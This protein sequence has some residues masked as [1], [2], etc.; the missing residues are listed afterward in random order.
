MIK[1]LARPDDKE[2]RE[3]FSLLRNSRSNNNNFFFTN[4]LNRSLATSQDHLCPICNQTLYN[5]E[6]LHKHHIIPFKEG[7]PTS[8]SN[9][10][11]IHQPCHN[12]NKITYQKDVSSRIKIQDFLLEYRKNH[13]NRLE[14]YLREQKKIGR[15]SSDITE[16]D[17][18][19]NVD[20]ITMD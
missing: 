9:L 2:F 1:N 6:G 15:K 7:G 4:K 8:F 13:K 14:Q 18:S 19:D 10:V 16:I 12:K 20:K 11:L 5:G 3:Y 17:F